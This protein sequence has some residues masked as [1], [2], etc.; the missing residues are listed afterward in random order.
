MPIDRRTLMGATLGLT[1]T[2]SARAQQWNDPPTPATGNPDAPQ[3][4]PAEHFALWTGK[5]PGTLGALPAP[6]DTMNGPAGRREL[7][8]RGIAAP[9]VGVLSPRQAGRARGAGDPRRRL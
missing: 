5:A 6:N 3:W 8:L 1:L 2:A 4:P 9:V 7:W